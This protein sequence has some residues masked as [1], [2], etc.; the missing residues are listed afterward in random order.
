L[1]GHKGFDDEEY[2]K[3]IMAKYDQGA[4]GELSIDQFKRLMFDLLK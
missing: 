3:S 2:L 1:F 4:Q